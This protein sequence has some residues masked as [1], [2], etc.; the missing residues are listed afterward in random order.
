VDGDGV[1]ARTLPGVDPKGAYLTRGSGHN[2]LGGYT[3]DAEEYAEVVERLA[4]KIQGSATAVPAPVLR[5]QPDAGIGIVAIGSSDPAVLEALDQLRER[6]IA[7]DYLRIRGFPFDRSV[8]EFL[9]AYPRVF[10]VEQNRDAQL[11][12]LLSLETGVSKDRLISVRYYGGLPISPDHVVDGITREIA[13]VEAEL[14][15]A[16]R[17]T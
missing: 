11:R 10:V 1:C 5:T 2:K 12:S 15:L 17:E 13:D 8:E 7:A 4:R 6:G 3:E 9:T 14:H 16:G